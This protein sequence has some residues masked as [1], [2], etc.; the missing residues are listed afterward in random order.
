MVFTDN[1]MKKIPGIFALLL[2]ALMFA[3]TTYTHQKAIIF[4]EIAALA[5]GSWVMERPPWHYTN[6]SIWISPSLAAL[7][8]VIIVRY[9]PYWG[10][11]RKRNL[12]Y[13]C[14]LLLQ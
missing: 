11:H 12:K 4:P 7:T 1:G 3:V 2:I 5:L 10:H 8:G 13:V 6:L 14:G 9:F